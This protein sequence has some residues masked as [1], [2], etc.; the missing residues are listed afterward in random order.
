MM[1]FVKFLEKAHKNHEVP[2][3][4]FYSI[5]MLYHKGHLHVNEIMYAH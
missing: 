5:A 4:Q 2:N 1:P 3:K